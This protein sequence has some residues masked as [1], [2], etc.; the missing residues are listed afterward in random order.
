LSDPI[1][2]I[3]PEVSIALAL[4]CNRDTNAPE[5]I[6]VGVV[7]LIVGGAGGGVP[8]VIFPPISIPPPIVIAMLL[9]LL[10]IYC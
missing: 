4:G 6:I 3:K 8:I 7:K 1:T 10:Y 2:V 5:F 9:I